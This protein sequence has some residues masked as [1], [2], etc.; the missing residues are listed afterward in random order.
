MPLVQVWTH[1]NNIQTLSLW[2]S[3][4]A[5]TP[6]LQKAQRPIIAFTGAGGKTSWIYALAQELRDNGKKVVIATTTKMYR[7]RRWGVIDGTIEDVRQQVYG[8]GIAVIGTAVGTEKIGYVGDA[9]F[10]QAQ[11]LADIVL[12][13]AD[14]AR[15]LPLKV[16]GQDEPVIPQGTTAICCVVGV[17]ALG[18]VVKEM[19]FRWDETT[20]CG[21]TI[22]TPDI[23]ITIWQTY[24]LD[25]LQRRYPDVP[26]I[27]II[28][29][30]DTPSLQEMGKDLLQHIQHPGIIS[31]FPASLRDKGRTHEP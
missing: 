8:D 11:A 27:P 30:A 3:L 15:R 9:F 21:E 4:S 6:A 7:P 28:H 19:C 24:C 1:K 31:T 23:L 2:E 12:V 18:Q 5:I 29:Q 26:V 17:S 22:I 10:T 14:G 16:T 13:E 25:V 20:M